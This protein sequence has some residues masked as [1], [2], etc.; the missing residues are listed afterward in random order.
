MQVRDIMEKNK[1]ISTILCLIKND[2]FI[3][4]ISSKY[5]VMK[6]NFFNDKSTLNNLYQ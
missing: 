3:K 6:Y 4:K 5:Q 1:I 2:N